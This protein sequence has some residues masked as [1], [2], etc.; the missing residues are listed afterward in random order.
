MNNLSSVTALMLLILDVVGLITSSIIAVRGEMWND[1]S[2]L[3]VLRPHVFP[4]NFR[5]I[6]NRD[7]K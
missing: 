4:L 2:K 5:V 6:T 3:L 1:W 7:P